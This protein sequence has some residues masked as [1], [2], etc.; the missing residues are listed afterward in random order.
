MNQN[1]I[2]SEKSGLWLKLA[3]AFGV[4]T[5]AMVGVAALGIFHSYDDQL[6]ARQIQDETNDE[7]N[8]WDVLAYSNVNAR[9]LLEA[10]TAR[11][12]GEIDELLARRTAN[13][14]KI[15]NLIEKMEDSTESSKEP[16]LVE[17]IKQRRAVYRFGAFGLVR[18]SRGKALSRL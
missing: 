9:L 14:E 8:A 16:E 17:K 15:S 13:S 6:E 4:L 3:L 2:F 18:E 1:S 12:T 5:A 7:R 10:F 11:N